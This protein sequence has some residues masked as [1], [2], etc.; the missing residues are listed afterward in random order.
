MDELFIDSVNHR[1]GSHQVLNSV[2][3]NCKVGEVVGVL[4][5]N[6]SGKSTLL[7]IIF[8]ALKPHFKFLRI[9]G[10]QTNNGAETGK[11]SY[12]PQHF[13][14]PSYLKVGDVISLFTRNHQSELRE[15]PL[16]A[17]VL[18]QKLYALSGGNRRLIETLAMIYSDAKYVLLD[19]PFSQ[20]APLLVDEIIG[21]INRFRKEKGFIITDHYFRQILKCSTR[22]VLIHNRCNYK[23]S[24]DE[25]LIVH[26]YLP[27]S[28][29]I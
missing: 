17:P 3:L 12:L 19:E 1:Y 7:R 14:I 20:M 28:V 24:S 18:D 15:H 26:G 16:V 22:V 23:I 29:M 2:Y 21:A 5:R 10:I 11:L 6:G 8:G 13:F 27:D 25:D 4:G 9:D